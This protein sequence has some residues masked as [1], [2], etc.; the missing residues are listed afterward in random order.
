MVKARIHDAHW[1]GAPWMESQRSPGGNDLDL[2]G[3]IPLRCVE[4]HNL[5][6]THGNYLTK[7]G[8]GINLCL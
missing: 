6:F 8:Y 3:E 7:I 4:D 1:N 2:M 5:G